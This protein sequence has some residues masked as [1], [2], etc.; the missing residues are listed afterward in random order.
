MSSIFLEIPSYRLVKV[1]QHFEGTYHLQL[2]GWTVSQARNQN[3]A[4]SKQSLIHAGSL[5]SL[6]FEPDDEGG[7]FFWILVD[8]HWTTQQYIPGDRTLHGHSYKNLK[9][10]M[11]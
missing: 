4:G 11:Y 9:S 7:M 5:L 10:K 6:L 1:N 2:Q 3:E 8:F